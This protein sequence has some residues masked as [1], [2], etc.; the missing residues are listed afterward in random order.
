MLDMLLCQTRR[1]TGVE[2][3]DGDPSSLSKGTEELEPEIR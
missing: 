2:I 1:E 3:V